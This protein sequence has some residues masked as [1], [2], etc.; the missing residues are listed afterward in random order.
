MSWAISRDFLEEA[1]PEPDLVAQERV[2]LV[3]DVG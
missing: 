2:G 3:A 1:V